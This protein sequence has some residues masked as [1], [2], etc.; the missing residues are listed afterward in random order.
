MLPHHCTIT[1]GEY[2]SCEV[3]HRNR[4]ENIMLKEQ[5]FI[6]AALTL[7]QE[8]QVVTTANMRQH[9]PQ[10]SSDSVTDF[11]RHWQVVFS[12]DEPLLPQLQP[13]LQIALIVSLDPED[14]DKRL[15]AAL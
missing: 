6:V 5:P 1:H 4:G 3:F 15:A 12:K 8:G 14:Q 7:E 10:E 2:I 9:L 11:V 13:K